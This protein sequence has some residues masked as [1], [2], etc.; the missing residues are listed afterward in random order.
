MKDV[1]KNA[2]K[3]RSLL[4]AQILWICVIAVFGFSMAGCAIF[5]PS[6]EV[7]SSLNGT[8]VYGD[9]QFRL[10][11]GSFVFYYRGAMQ[12]RGSYKTN[13]SNITL[14]VTDVQVNA[15][16][17]TR[18]ELSSRGA[19]ASDLDVMFGSWTG[20]VSGN[21]L[22]LKNTGLG[23][24]ETFTNN[25]R[26]ASSASQSQAPSQTARYLLVN[27]DTLNVRSGPSADS[28]IVNTLPRNTRVE[29][30]DR[31]AG[32]WWKIRSGRIEGYVNSTLLRNE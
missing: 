5:T 3:M 1:Q 30:I 9:D 20:T 16:W 22:T 8:W 17:C 18:S 19:A 12:Q 13:G 27:T 11:N 23:M 24:T 15:T 28:A 2:A 6:G 26:T 21:T 25:N 7:D 29:V 32:T 14:T 4:A 10:T 31:S